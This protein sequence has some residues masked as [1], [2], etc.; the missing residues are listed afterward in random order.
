[1]AKIALD[2]DSTL[3][4]YWGLLQR[5][6]KERYGVDLPYSCLLYTSP[7]PRDKS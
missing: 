5:V 1:M 3:H 6:A 7:S 4:E 2:I